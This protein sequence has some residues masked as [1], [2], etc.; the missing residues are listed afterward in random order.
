MSEPS[1]ATTHA[2]V[3]RVRRPAVALETTLI[4]HGVPREAA[5]PLAHQLA[6]IVRSAGATPAFI[7]LVAGIPT[8]GMTDEELRILMDADT[9]PKANTSNIGVLIHRRSHGATTVGTTLEFA[10]AAGIRLFATGGL[11]GA[12]RD[13]GR[14]W[15]VSGDLAALARF[16]VAVVTSGTK[17]I[18]DVGSTREMLE[19]LGIPVVGFGTDRFPAF[20]LR[21]SDSPLDA[22][23]DQPEDLAGFISAELARTGRGIVI[24]NPIPEPDAIDPTLWERWLQEAVSRAANASGRDITPRILAELHTI[25]G[26]RTLRANLSLIRSNTAL[27]A[28]LSVRLSEPD[29]S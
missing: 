8:V 29:H 4:L 12:H 22:R 1:H 18:L 7:G 26:G 14:R 20:Y 10:A 5:R 28:E 23:F 9:I 21:E 27:A 3:N 16:P 17:S 24:A 19:T 25:S 2:I 11:G 6:G 15:D 13:F